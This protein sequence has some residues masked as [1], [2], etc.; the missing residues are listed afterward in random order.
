MVFEPTTSC[1]RVRGVTETQATEGTSN[2]IPIHAPVI[3]QILWNSIECIFI[4]KNSI[5]RSDLS[6]HYSVHTQVCRSDG[7]SV[8]SRRSPHPNPLRRDTMLAGIPSYSTLLLCL[9]IGL[10]VVHVQCGWSRSYRKGVM[11]QQTAN[12]GICCWNYS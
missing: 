12:R 1:L 4:R 10:P 11:H 8:N 6:G 7:L 9:E 5:E 3:Y 2:L